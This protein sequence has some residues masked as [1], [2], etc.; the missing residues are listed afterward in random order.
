MARPYTR[1]VDGASDFD[2]LKAW[3]QGH[4]EAGDALCQR[5]YAAILRFFELRSG[6]AEDLV[7]HTFLAAVE[8]RE[9]FRQDGSF[10]SY[11]FSI[12][13]K[14]LLKQIARQ[15]SDRRRARFGDRSGERTTTVSALMAR[16][17]EQRILLA[18]LSTLKEGDQ[19]IIILHYWENLCSREIGEVLSIPTS[20]V[21]TRLSRARDTLRER[22]Q[23]FA[24]GR[25]GENALHDLEDWTRSLPNTESDSGI[26]ESVLLGLRKSVEAS[27]AAVAGDNER[28]RY[29]VPGDAGS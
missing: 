10:R 18:V 4:S 20:T 13:H 8:G 22:V 19:S 1:R 7:Q 24:T 25:A 15:Q 26:P 5:Y 9:R 27:R 2:L 16:R 29:D 17:Q 12:A 3:R 21:T 28:S 11:L 23:K 14:Q 6:V